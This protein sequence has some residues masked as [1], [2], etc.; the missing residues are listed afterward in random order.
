LAFTVTSFAWSSWESS[1]VLANAGISVRNR[2]VGFEVLEGRL[3][4]E[5]ALDVGAL[6]R[7][8]VHV[9]RPHLLQEEWA[10]RDTRDSG[11]I[12]R[13]VMNTLRASSARTKTI[14]RG[15]SPNLER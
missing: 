4:L 7:D 6:G 8:L 10:V 15:D 2:V 13:L 9:A 14:Q 5:R 12:V 1:S 3:F 11:P